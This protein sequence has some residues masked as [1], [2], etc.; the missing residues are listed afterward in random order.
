M[1]IPAFS[2]R[3]HALSAATGGHE[4]E[5]LLA[6]VYIRVLVVLDA[7]VHDHLGRVGGEDRRVYRQICGVTYAHIEESR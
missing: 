7:L 6:E 3:T 4:I 5:D 1:S 2:G